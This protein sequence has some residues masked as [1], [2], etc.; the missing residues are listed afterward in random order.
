MKDVNGVILFFDLSNYNSD[1]DLLLKINEFKDG[2]NER[3]KEVINN[4]L[5]TSFYDPC[6]STSPSVLFLREI[7]ED[8]KIDSLHK[9]FSSLLYDKK[10][11]TCIDEDVRY[12]VTS[13]YMEKEDAALYMY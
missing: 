1:K 9:Y 7:P 6:T 5:L 8:E 13:Y 3:D 10:S 2:L 12:N 4:G 11:T